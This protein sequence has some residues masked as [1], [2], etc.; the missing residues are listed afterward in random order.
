MKTESKK[1]WVN[2]EFQIVDIK[3]FSLDEF[4]ERVLCFPVRTFMDEKEY[5]P[6]LVDMCWLKGAYDIRR[7]AGVLS[8]GDMV[9]LYKAVLEV[10]PEFDFKYYKINP[11]TI[12]KEE[13]H[14]VKPSEPKEE[15][16]EEEFHAPLE[17]ILALV[18]FRDMMKA[19]DKEVIGQEEAVDSLC[20]KLIN[21][22]HMGMQKDGVA[23]YYLYGP[24]GVGKTS[25]IKFLSEFLG[26]SPCYIQGSEYKE[27]HSDSKLFGAPPSY[28]GYD[29]D[30][31]ILTRYIKKNPEGIV[32]FDEIDKVHPAIYGTLTNFLGDGFL[33]N[34][35]GEQCPFN[36]FV[37]FTSNT[38]NK[39][40][41]QGMGRE[42]G[43]QPK[44]ISQSEI[45]KKRIFGILREQGLQEA[46][47]GRI[48][49]FIGFKKLNHSRLLEILDKEID[50]TNE[51]LRYYQI[52]LN[53]SAKEGI[54][55]LGDPEN[56][57]ARNIAHN[58]ENY[59][60]S[61][62]SFEFEMRSGLEDGSVVKVN[63]EE[64]KFIYSIDEEVLMEIEAI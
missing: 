11:S 28:V 18:D 59:I 61:E 26:I 46:F 50:E 25:S 42:I 22:K 24:S 38:G 43:F 15:K 63:F 13:K 4:K 2:N 62:L 56:W 32:L 6:K 21:V 29:E 7:D 36:G 12:R 47:L 41:E 51:S 53:E 54:I 64:D 57:G 34:P 8:Y 35:A 3:K 55:K 52:E 37:F 20:R 31:G 1:V 45:E 49:D 5:V 10:N 48:N 14:I 9:N 39:L 16:C 33:I 23:S 58:I 19:F 30:G 17:E 60:T 44:E 27:H 40:T